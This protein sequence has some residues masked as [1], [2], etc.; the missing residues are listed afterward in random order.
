MKIKD[1]AFFKTIR[2]FLTVYLPK[3]R[4]LSENTIKSY[5]EALNLMLRYLEEEK[6]VALNQISFSMLDHKTIASFLDWLESA[7]KC[8]I[9]T[10]NQRLAALS[11]F[12]KYA[13]IADISQRAFHNEIKKVPVKKAPGTV[14]EFLTKDELK[15]LLSQPDTRSH[16]GLRNQ[17]MMILMFDA[18]LRCQEI[19]DMKIR[20]FDGNT[21]A[22]HIYVTGKGEKPRRIPIMNKT[23]EHFHQ[24]ISV[25]HPKATWN[26]DDL[27]FYTVIH[28]ERKP[29]S[30]D[31]V[32]R[33]IKQYGES[34]HKIC[35]KM[36]E[37]VHPH[38]LRHTRAIHLYREGMPLPILAEFLGHSDIST[39]QIYA[40][41]DP[42]MKRKAIQKAKGDDFPVGD[43]LP[44]WKNDTEMIKKLCGLK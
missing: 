10:R 2:G 36:P 17:F 34:A 35:P 42:E 3:Q 38:Q 27:L 44:V 15:T 28:G 23:V 32:E 24:Y 25:F 26:K 14:V 30:A 11:S 40:Y 20:D 9:S 7:R 43:E 16:R 6:K 33:F 31:N 8:S 12:F 29:M 13:G 22:P 4:R 39:T 37:R 1:E 41:A 5:K 18:A 21:R 19:L